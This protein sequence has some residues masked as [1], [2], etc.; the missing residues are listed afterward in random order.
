M[1]VIGHR[2][3]AGLA[4]E[5][6]MESL[7]AGVAA[8]VDI[9]EFDIRLTKD[10]IPV[11][12]HNATTTKTHSARIVV[13]RHTLDELQAMELFPTIP[14]LQEV[15]DEFF[16]VILL[17]IELKVKGSA[18]I[19]MDLLKRRYIKRKKDW[20]N[21][22]LSSFRAK[23]LLKARSISALVPLAMLHDQNPF[24]FI[25]YERRLRLSAVGFHRLYVNRLAVEIAHRIGLFCYA[26][27]VDRPYG[28]FVLYSQSAIDGIVTNKPDIIL[29]EIKKSAS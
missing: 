25:A 3:A 5:N 8:G 23:E 22:L 1:L 6:T 14:T 9:L 12:I 18:T 16:G 19:V 10:N 29:N 17:N 13:A 2:G 21:I 28:A 27:T 7:R 15:L 20:H 26:Y 11:V 4:P 24:L